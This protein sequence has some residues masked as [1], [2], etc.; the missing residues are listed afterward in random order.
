MTESDGINVKRAH[1]IGCWTA[2]LS[3]VHRRFFIS[4][5]E[6]EGRGL[7]CPLA[8]VGFGCRYHGFATLRARVGCSSTPQSGFKKRNSGI[9]Q[10]TQTLCVEIK[11][12]SDQSHRDIFLLVFFFFFFFGIAHNLWLGGI[13]LVPQHTACLVHLLYSLLKVCDKVWDTKSSLPRWWQR[14]VAWGGFFFFFFG[15]RSPLWPNK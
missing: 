12:Q 13:S 8:V 10:C 4:Q 15:R 6:F 5:W 3:W 14:E 7:S 11:T 9:H 1:D 2:T